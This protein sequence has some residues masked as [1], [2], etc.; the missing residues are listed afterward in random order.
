MK[1]SVFL[2]VSEAGLYQLYVSQKKQARYV[3]SLHQTSFI[4]CAQY[5]RKK[6]VWWSWVYPGLPDVSWGEARVPPPRLDSINNQ[7]TVV[8]GQF[9]HSCMGFIA[10]DWFWQRSVNVRGPALSSAVSILEVTHNSEHLFISKTSLQ[11]IWL[12]VVIQELLYK[13][14]LPSVSYS[15]G[16]VSMVCGGGG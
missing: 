14:P 11:L 13:Q 15:W 5:I 16:M 3:V 6:S 4:L 9:P 8:V 7:N 12:W 1:W 2:S 10:V